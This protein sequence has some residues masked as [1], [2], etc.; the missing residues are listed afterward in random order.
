MKITCKLI[1]LTVV[2]RNGTSTLKTS[3]LYDSLSLFLHH[4]GD[5]GYNN[6]RDTLNGIVLIPFSRCG[7]QRG[8][9]AHHPNWM[10]A[11]LALS[12]AIFAWISSRFICTL[13]FRGWW[14]SA[15]K[16][17]WDLVSEIGTSCVFSSLIKFGYKFRCNV[18]DRRMRNLVY[19]NNAK[20]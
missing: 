1:S 13:S 8:T 7:C 16:R 17:E 6:V 20:S 18:H 4:L 3:R 9:L 11:W 15:F 5:W 12:P 10:T 14:W 19:V 2:L